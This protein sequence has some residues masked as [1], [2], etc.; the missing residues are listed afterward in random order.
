LAKL[1]EG[2]KP[3]W[4]TMTPQ[5]MIEHLERTIRIG[6]GQIQNFEI[7]TPEKYLEK[8]QEMIYNHKKMPRAV[9]H[10]LMREGELEDLIH[11]DLATA[12]SKLIE[13]YDT[14]ETYFKENPE[15]ITKNAVFGEMNKFEWDL[16][17]TKH[18]NHHFEQ[19]GILK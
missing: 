3:N 5:H 8:V 4:G 13:A 1:T 7:A 10:P 2:M 16:L 11:E 17:N 14:F 6:A 15:A 9:N 18:M 19:F 12:K